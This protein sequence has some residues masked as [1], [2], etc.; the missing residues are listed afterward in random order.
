MRLHSCNLGANFNSVLYLWHRGARVGAILYVSERFMRRIIFAEVSSNE[1]IQNDTPIAGGITEH[2]RANQRQ[3][4]LPEVG[5][6]RLA[7]SGVNFIALCE[8]RWGND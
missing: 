2:L 8:R 6:E 5:G 1:A 3:S 4:M 7:I